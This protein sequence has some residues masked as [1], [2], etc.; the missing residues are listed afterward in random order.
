[1]ALEAYKP[2]SVF[3]WNKATAY[4][5]QKL[6]KRNYLLTREVCND[7]HQTSPTDSSRTQDHSHT[8]LQVQV[9]AR[10]QP[11][12]THLKQT[13]ERNS[14]LVQAQEQAPPKNTVD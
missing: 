6:A 14:F 5:L 12:Q 9:K 13:S 8:I 2:C 3:Q 4:F 11:F 7:P 1:M 10:F